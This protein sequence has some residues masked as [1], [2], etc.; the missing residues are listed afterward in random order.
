[1]LL[2][3]VNLGCIETN[4]W[5]SSVGLLKY[6]DYLVTDID[7]EA[8]P[9]NKFGTTNVSVYSVR[10]RPGAICFSPCSDAE[11]ISKRF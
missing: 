5:G 11:S 3:T 2:H 8:V 4:P 10:S 7:P 9:Q 1:M 6:P